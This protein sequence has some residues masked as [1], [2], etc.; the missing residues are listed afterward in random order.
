MYCVINW[1]HICDGRLP[2]GPTSWISWVWACLLVCMTLI[3]VLIYWV[4]KKLKTINARIQ[5]VKR[6]VEAE[7]VKRLDLS[8]HWKL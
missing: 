7:R 4:G 6:I 8:F 2:R 3:F 1:D 5:E